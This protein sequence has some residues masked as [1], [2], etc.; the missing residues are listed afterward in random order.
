[1][2]DLQR[3][4]K[5]KLQHNASR[6]PPKISTGVKTQILPSYCMCTAPLNHSSLISGGLWFT[7]KERHEKNHHSG[8]SF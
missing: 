4:K 6:L 3:K 7:D 5:E 2:E 8:R 1:M